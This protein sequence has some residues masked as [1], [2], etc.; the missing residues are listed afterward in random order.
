MHVSL[1]CCDIQWAEKEAARGMAHPTE[2]DSWRV[3]RIARYLV[4]HPVQE[5]IYVLKEMPQIIRTTVDADWAGCAVSRKS[6]SGGVVRL[7]ECILMTWARTQGAI[8]LS[9][10]ESEY[11]G[12]VTG[13]Q[14]S[15]YV[16]SVASE[17]GY[18]L[19]IVLQSDST[20]AQAACERR[21]AL[22][23]K[24]MALRMMF[25]KELV[26]RK[27]VQIERVS[28]GQNA[29]D[30]LTKALGSAGHH[31]CLQLLPGLLVKT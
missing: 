14:E 11:R 20:S 22:H 29:A 24:H 8:A 2:L 1:D 23:A 4:H 9:T 12:L 25:I 10:M 28:S 19:G 15:M 13:A 21:G 3:T 17:L 5:W 31:R 7:G 26:E 30:W 16:Q 18:T 27:L 6:T